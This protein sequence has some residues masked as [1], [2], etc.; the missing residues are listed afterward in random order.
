MNIRTRFA[1]SPTGIMHIGNVRTALMNYLFAQQK[2]GSFIL[3]VE[4]TDPK[5]NFDPGAKQIIAHLTW[6]GITF[7][8][9][10]GVGGD[11]APYFQSERADIYKK[12]L[13]ELKEKDFIYP[14][15]CTSEELDKKRERQIAMKRPP[16]YDR[17]CLNLSEEKRAEYV[18]SKPF[19]WRMKVD[20]SK[21]IQFPDLSHGTLNFDLKNFSDFPIS[22]ADGSS[23]F[24]FANCVDDI[25]M[26]ITYVLRGED[27]LTNSVGQVVMFEAFGAKVPTFWHLPVLCNVTGKKLSKRDQ[28]FSLNDLHEEGFLP[29]AICNY[30]GIL[31]KSFTEE[32]LSLPE[33]IKN[34]D[35]ETI[36]AASQIKYDLEK[37]RWVNHKWIERYDLDAL[38]TAS[39]PFLAKKYDISSTTDE[40]LKMLLGI[41]QPNMVTLKN[42]ASLLEFYFAAP[43]VS[44]QEIRQ[45]ISE[46][47]AER[48]LYI[49]KKHAGEENFYDLVSQDASEEKIPKKAIWST[50]RYVLTG[51][52]RG[53]QIKELLIALSAEEIKKRISS[54]K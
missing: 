41:I 23:T 18:A 45:L 17:T 49:L 28:G 2:Q 8:E 37:L 26:N 10:P 44:L 12:R 15:F 43:K 35:F 48:A 52:A 36:H 34:Y 20:S 24:M 30:L 46:E 27:H 21:K 4:D 38:V 11:A 53:L 25:E 50:F 22:R 33:L 6:L 32:I 54:V 39:K 29:E 16:R 31:G 51:S 47:N 19:I 3:R 13:E 1:P 14:C 42:A 7:D 9:G 5:R 40:Q